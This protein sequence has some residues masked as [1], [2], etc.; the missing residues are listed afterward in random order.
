MALHR[1]RRGEQAVTPE[2]A[3]RLGK[4]YG[5]GPQF[6]LWMQMA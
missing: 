6:W 4:L 2:M 5:N 1:L 3:L